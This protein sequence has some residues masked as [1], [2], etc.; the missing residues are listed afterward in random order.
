MPLSATVDIQEPEVDAMEASDCYQAA[1]V[2][3]LLCCCFY[4]G[5]VPAICSFESVPTS[6]VGDA[7]FISARYICSEIKL[8]P[9]VVNK[10]FRNKLFKFPGRAVLEARMLH[11]SIEGDECGIFFS[12]FNIKARWA[13][14]LQPFSLP[15]L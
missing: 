11:V 4:F 8:P 5:P 15:G 6:C 2:E 3:V 13:Q 7:D 14:I 12:W 10:E 1:F 9:S